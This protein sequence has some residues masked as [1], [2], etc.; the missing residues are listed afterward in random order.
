MKFAHQ[1]TAAFVM[2]L[3]M[4]PAAL[5]T[6]SHYVSSHSSMPTYGH[7][8]QYRHNDTKPQLEMKRSDSKKKAPDCDTKPVAKKP[9]VKKPVAP[10]HNYEAPKP[11]L[12]HYDRPEHGPADCDHTKPTP[13]PQPTPT[14]TPAPAPQPAP[15]V[16]SAG[17][18]PAV[19][20]A[21]VVAP[22][23]ATL[24]QTGAEMPIALFTAL[25]GAAAVYRKVRK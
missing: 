19:T 7:V 13:K 25:G 10:K 18:T 16:G 12:D 24:P 20:P 1:A 2:T 17:A 8:D 9:E 23:P 5:A 22:Q 6:N 3:C 21:P 4:A 14:P 11:K 15:G